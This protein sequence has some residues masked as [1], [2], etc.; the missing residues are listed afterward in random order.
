MTNIPN[1]SFVENCRFKF[2]CHKTWQSL[3]VKAAYAENRR[4]CS[5]C[6]YDVYLVNND[7]ELESAILNNY[8]V[9]IPVNSSVDF[10]FV[11][12]TEPM[13]TLGIPAPREPEILDQEVSHLKTGSNL[14]RLL[15]LA[16]ICLG[17][18]FFIII[19]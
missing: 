1:Q 15:I 18:Y 9:A 16:L 13:T 6:N 14:Y 5:Q 12:H 3:E 7:V 8:C 11:L 19:K 17:I 4:F 10:S 2:K